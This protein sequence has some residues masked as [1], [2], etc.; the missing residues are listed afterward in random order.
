MIKFTAQ[1]LAE[2]F[3]FLKLYVDESKNASHKESF[4]MFF[5]YLSSTEQKIKTIFLSIVNI[6]GKAAGEIM[7]IIQLFLQQILW[8]L[9]QYHSV[10]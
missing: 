6:E 9:T 4:L 7:D 8:E 10:F 3:I 1:K 2:P 5:T